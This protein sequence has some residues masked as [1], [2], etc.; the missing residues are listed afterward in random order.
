MYK[1]K[2]LKKLILITKKALEKP[3]L[4]IISIEL[5]KKYYNQSQTSKSKTKINM[6]V[7][8]KLEKK[9]KTL[10]RLSIICS[11]KRNITKI[12]DFKKIHK[13]K[14]SYNNLYVWSSSNKIS[15]YNYNLFSCITYSY[16]TI[17]FG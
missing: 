1:N 8:K 9:V 2:L 7:I 6:I 4:A 13:T 17:S 5:G 15:S 12:T 14:S 10:H 11:I 3:L 16:Y